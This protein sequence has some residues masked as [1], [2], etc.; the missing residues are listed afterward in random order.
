MNEGADAGGIALE[1]WDNSI[2]ISKET[3]TIVE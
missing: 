1:E 2:I 3:F